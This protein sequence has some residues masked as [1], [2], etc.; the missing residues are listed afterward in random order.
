M[1]VCVFL[2]V[3]KFDMPYY[4]VIVIIPVILKCCTSQKQPNFVNFITMNSH[5]LFNNGHF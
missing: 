1:C 5:Q 2:K 3:L 4:D